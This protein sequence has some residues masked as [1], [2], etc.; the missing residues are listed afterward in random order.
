M[1][2]L[3]TIKTEIAKIMTSIILN[4]LGKKNI[5]AVT[6]SKENA[7]KNQGRTLKESAHL[8]ANGIEAKQGMNGTKNTPNNSTGDIMKESQNNANIAEKPS[9]LKAGI[10][11]SAQMLANQHGEEKQ[12]LTML[13]KNVQCVE[14]LSQVTNM[15]K[16][17]VVPVV[18]QCV[19]DGEIEPAVYDLTVEEQHE[20]FANGVLV[21]NCMDSLR[22]A[23]DGLIKGR[24]AMH[25]DSKA[26]MNNRFKRR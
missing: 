25:I 3:S 5:L 24:G 7:L 10:M 21:H 17:N 6:Q 18:V 15:Q 14:S 13:Q 19:R 1:A 22:Y 20:F 4:V 11:L 12:G 8:P 9:R 16:W 23:L 26:L 2:M